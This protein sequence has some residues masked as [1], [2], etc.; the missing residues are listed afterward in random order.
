MRVPGF[1]PHLDIALLAHLVTQEEVDFYKWF[2]KLS[3]EDKLKFT[4][5]ELYKD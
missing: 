2:D 5:E 4:E 1:D 3:D